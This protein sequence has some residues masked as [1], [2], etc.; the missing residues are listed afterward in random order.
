MVSKTKRF[1][2]PN[3][4]EYMGNQFQYN[5]VKLLLTDIDYLTSACARLKP[6]YFTAEGLNE[7][8]SSIVNRWKNK[9]MPSTLEDVYLELRNKAGEDQTKHRKLQVLLDQI[10]SADYTNLET[11]KE[12]LDNFLNVHFIFDL[13]NDMTSK[14]TLES[15]FGRSM[16]VM[17][18]I[19]DKIDIALSTTVNEGMNTN[20]I[21][22]VDSVFNE[23]EA[24]R[25]PTGEPI[26]DEIFRGGI[27]KRTLAGIIAPTGYGKS[28]LS[29]LLAYDAAIA[30]YNV[31]HFFFEDLP[32]DIAK[33][34][35]ARMTSL[36]IGDIK[37]G[38]DESRNTI[39]MNEHVEALKE[40]SRI[41]SMPNG[42]TT[43][44]DIE[45]VLRTLANVH[46]FV[47]DMVIIDYYDCL[48]FSRN[49]IKDSL[50][51]DKACVKK[52][53]YLAKKLN[54]V[55][56]I[57]N[58][59][60]R[61]ATAP[62]N[63]YELSLG[64]CIQ[65]V[66]HRIQT[67]AYTIGLRQDSGDEQS[68]AI[69][70]EKNRSGRRCIIHNLKLDNGTVSIDWSHHYITYID[71]GKNNDNELPFDDELAYRDYSDEPNIQV[72]DVEP[73]NL[74]LSTN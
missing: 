22:Y 32:N 14:A 18:N 6:E 26:L 4:L 19:R 45:L 50:A 13:A 49:P 30:G 67:C 62:T 29:T 58:Q 1:E 59:T 23:D 10:K 28:T 9:H 12:Q 57:A 61:M 64:K 60:N 24:V 37:K 2:V 27:P 70:I 40:H 39:E 51:A 5:A 47:P 25:I 46:G 8:V 36:E 55:V 21:D 54:I 56:W 42:E 16:N 66:H 72:H 63:D 7:V 33:K 65:G 11:L 44:E 17:M 52:L 53:E 15:N 48:K 41:I 69:E 68:R 38:N 3:N 74:Y 43:V 71:N 73:G 20:P 35:F 31:V 34:Y